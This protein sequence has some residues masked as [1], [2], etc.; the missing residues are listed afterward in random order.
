[1]EETNLSVTTYFIIVGIS[2]LPMLRFAISLLILF[3]YLITLGGNTMIFLLVCFDHHLHTPMYFF[4]SNLSI[5][6]I[7]CSTNNLQN[8]L[9][10]F[11]SSNNS[12]SHLHCVIQIFLF[13]SLT[14][15]ELL[16][17]T[18][19]SY[20]RYVAICNPLGYNIIMNCRICALLAITCWIWGALESFPIL[21]ELLKLTCYKS[22]K[23]NHFLCDI[24][25][26]M[27]L[28]CSD[29]HF[30]NL[31]IV[32]AVI[33]GVCPF[34]LTVISY[35][36]I[37]VSIIK[38]HSTTGRLKAFYTCSSHLSVVILLYTAIFFQYMSPYT[39]SNFDSSKVPSLFVTAVV[40]FLNPL[41]YS[42][43]NRD[44]ISAL[45]RRFGLSAKE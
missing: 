9:I 15:G 3:I 29:T 42:L 34:L 31:Y 33:V 19:M 22:N 41:I 13:L 36:F 27:K 44:V 20:D 8:T 2:D 14:S 12:V 45:R 17:L 40:P 16:L 26:V 6:D 32:S 7:C 18:A 38:I 43:K 28:T 10:S 23:I 1:M 30:L 4:L 21:L 37:I 25:P 24:M 35:V 11:M 39:Y 5:L